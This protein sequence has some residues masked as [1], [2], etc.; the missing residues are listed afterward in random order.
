MPVA[1]AYDVAFCEFLRPLEGLFCVLQAGGEDGDG[2][3]ELSDA[4]FAGPAGKFAAAEAE[5]LPG[6]VAPGFVWFLVVAVRGVHMRAMV[7]SSLEAR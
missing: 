1:G 5:V 6:A 2:V 7:M 3:F 4:V